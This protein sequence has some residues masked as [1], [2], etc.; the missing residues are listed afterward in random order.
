MID[1]SIFRSYDI[2]GVYPEAINECLAEK[3]GFA[4]V[5]HLKAKEVV[6]GRDMRLSSPVLFA[7]LV[8]GINQAGADVVDIG[9]VPTPVTY[10]AVV[11]LKA[12]AGIMISASHNPPEYNGFK[13]VGKKAI[14]LSKESGIEDI[15]KIVL[16]GAQKNRGKRGKVKKFDI[17][18]A[19]YNHILR[20]VKPT[21]RRLKVVIDAGNGMGGDFF[22]PVFEKLNVD[23]IPMYFE[24]D[25]TYPNHP[26]NPAEYENLTHLIKKVK[27][28]KA[29]LGVAFDGDAD[30]AI[31][32]DEN[33]VLVRPDV[34]LALLAAQELKNHKNKKV[35][36]D[37]RFSKVAVEVLRGA[38][39]QVIR[40]R[41]GNPYYKQRLI[42]EGGTMAAELSG[43][44][45]FADGF[46]LDDGL[47]PVVKLVNFLGNQKKTFSS[48]VTKLR[49][50]VASPG[51]I[52][53]KVK[54]SKKVLEALEK[55]YGVM[56]KID[57][58]DGLTVTA[59]DWWFNVRAS[60]T[61]PVIRLTLETKPDEKF[62][63]EKKEEILSEIGKV[64]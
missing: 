33:G 25:G 14:Q 22:K 9:M 38:G 43:H 6:V 58:L 11:H 21:T 7:S 12:K 39:A 37:L 5:K 55:K 4:V 36:Y 62:M 24:P 42:G 34:Y 45:M 20:F 27:R 51:E 40:T 31:F 44:I 60:N 23:Y 10:F 50:G 8:R 29:D 54:G 15:K 53:L 47:L 59:K 49:A 32:V 2:R 64:N 41:V 17:S 63:A 28:V 61:E 48:L 46:G 19:Y 35:Y 56:G 57:K 26:A 3:V 52:N 30:R 16:E 1:P 18:G 13:I